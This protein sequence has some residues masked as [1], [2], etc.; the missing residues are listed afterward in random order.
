MNRTTNRERHPLSFKK[1]LILL[2]S[3]LLL[4]CALLA[5]FVLIPLLRDFRPLVVTLHNE[6]GAELTEIE[7]RIDRQDDAK[8]VYPRPVPRGESR[9]I[10]PELEMQGAGELGLRAVGPGG[11]A[12]GGTICG[13][14]ESLSG[15]VTVTIGADG[16]MAVQGECR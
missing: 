15:A 5:V 16:Q 7:L 10:R 11:E 9:N 12:Y 3:V 1:R 4:G 14:T 8:Y 13:Y 2:L 6:S